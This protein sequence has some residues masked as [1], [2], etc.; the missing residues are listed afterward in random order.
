[1]SKS[2][3]ELSKNAREKLIFKLNEFKGKHYLDVRVYLVGE[4]GGQ[5]VPTK[6]GLTLAV[7]LY[8]QFKEAL[9]RVE[10]VMVERGLLDRED[11]EAQE[12]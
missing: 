4:N 8:P 11:L 12:E 2:I 6:K 1:M 10:A 7:N 3:C 9:G 5:P